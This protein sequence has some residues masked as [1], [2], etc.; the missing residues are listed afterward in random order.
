V[1]FMIS[2]LLGMC[3]SSTRILRIT[4][5]FNHIPND[6]IGRANSVFMVV[7]TTFRMIFVSLFSLAFFTGSNH[8]VYAYAIF[9][10]FAFISL[11]LL[12][13]ISARLPKT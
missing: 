6:I 1:V 5:L 3:N 4:Y 9:G 2:F 11:I 8:V 10:V 7:N 12:I 13:L